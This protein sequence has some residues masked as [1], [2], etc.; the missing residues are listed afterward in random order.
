MTV[1]TMLLDTQLYG[2]RYMRLY[3]RD[4]DDFDELLAAVKQC[5]YVFA[6]SRVD[7]GEI[8]GFTMTPKQSQIVGLTGTPDEVLAS[9]GQRSRQEI[10]KT[11]RDEDLHVVADDPARDETYRFYS[12]VKREEG[13]DPDVAEDFESARWINAYFRGEL[14]SVN[15]VYSNRN[16]I[17]GKHLASLRKHSNL[18]PAVIG[19]INRRLLWE[20]CALGI[21]EGRT[22]FDMGGVDFTDPAKRGI[23]EFKRRFGGE[24]VNI[25]IYRYTTPAWADVTQQQQEEGKEIF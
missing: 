18:D 13:A 17:R 24:T 14:V 23:S 21:A 11:Y 3:L 16:V 15:S 6:Y 25:Y 2:H 4:D 1:K 7:F 10:R 20:A 8:D 12:G 19:R 5:D 9:L 22:E